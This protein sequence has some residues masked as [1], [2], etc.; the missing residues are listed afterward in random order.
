MN[1]KN[2]IISILLC[3]T[4]LSVGVFFGFKKGE[5]AGIS[6]GYANGYAEGE[7][8]G[9][10]IGFSNGELIG[11][12][13]GYDECNK[14]YSEMLNKRYT[15]EEAYRLGWSYWFSNYGTRGSGLGVKYLPYYI[16]GRDYKK[17]FYTVKDAFIAGFND[18][19]YYVNHKNPGVEYDERIV[20]GL[21]EYFD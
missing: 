11:Y 16:Y 2:I 4:F 10:D 20:K 17:N 6:I 7:K 5:N 13:K 14:K 1:I 12:E 18:G 15:N 21:N 9:F 19:F 3:L 8:V